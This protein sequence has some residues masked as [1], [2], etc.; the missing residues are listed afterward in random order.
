MKRAKR[1]IVILSLALAGCRGT[2]GPPAATPD[3]LSL[4]ILTTPATAALIQELAAEYAPRGTIVNL[5][6]ATLRWDAIAQQLL[7]G[8]ASYALT[9][10]LPPAAGL[11]TAPI[12]YDALAIVVPATM[13]VDA[14]T[15]DQVRRLFL[16]QIAA[17]DEL[18]GPDVPVTVVVQEPGSEASRVFQSQVM[19]GQ[20][21]TL[22]ARL[23]LSN[24]SMIDLVARTPGA[25]GYV[26]MAA[27]S[28]S[29]HAV[30]L[31]TKNGPAVA[32][33]HDSVS[34]GDYPLR[35]PILITGLSAPDDDS[36]FYAWFAWM[37]SAEG[38]AVVSRQYAALRP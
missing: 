38:Q 3:V 1:T 21:V 4:H 34:R 24:A 30:P 31:G 5:R 28:E 17:W 15:L 32:L 26:S 7:A 25:I 22:A 27:L 11:W 23:A 13:P 8:Q 18:G 6:S 10:Y 37:Q 19:N 20:R 9:T 33:S 35:M 16:G 12:G 36:A 2:I 29:V 14:L